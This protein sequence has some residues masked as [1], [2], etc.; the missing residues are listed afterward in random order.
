MADI[1]DTQWPINYIE[2]RS[3]AK[4][5]LERV[6]NIQARKQAVFL[7][8]ILEP[9]QSEWETAF[10][11]QTGLGLP[12]PVGTKLIWVDW[13]KGDAKS[14]VTTND[15]VA[16]QASSGTVYPYLDTDWDRPSI[17]LLGKANLHTHPLSGESI[18]IVP[19]DLSKNFVALIFNKNQ[20]YRWA[21][22]GLQSFMIMYKIRVLDTS[23]GDLTLFF[24]STAP[25]DDWQEDYSIAA[26][27]AFYVEVTNA[28]TNLG[29]NDD[30]EKSAIAT[31]ITLSSAY[32]GAFSEGVIFLHRYGLATTTSG[33]VHTPT[34][35]SLAPGGLHIGSSLG[36]T[37]AANNLFLQQ[38]ASQKSDEYPMREDMPRVGRD[39]GGY[40]LDSAVWVYGLFKGLT[41]ELV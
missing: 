10:V 39:S 14:F 7:R 35:V 19:V 28:A 9:T 21:Q 3:F 13:S 26:Q 38:A 31:N 16:G 36:A 37:F 22:L 18:S 17:R 11:S 8:Q 27:K 25:I 6:Q 20:L 4:L 29:V 12:I 5:L 40:N 30:T 1:Y 32:S 2:Q 24:R 41:G 34:D 15:L 23:A 33:G